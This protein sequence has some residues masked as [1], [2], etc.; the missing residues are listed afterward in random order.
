[1]TASPSLADDL[2]QARRAALSPPPVLA[3][4]AWAA[5]Y[6]RLPAGANAMPGRFVAFGYQR[7]WLDVM[8]DA[9]V[10]QCTIMKSARVGATRCL[11]HVIGYYIHQ[12]PAPIL[13]VL[14]RVEDCEDFSRSEVLPMLQDTPALAAIVGDIK[15][16]DANQRIL[17]RTFRNGASISFVGAT[18]PA[19]FRRIS[20]RIILLD[21]RRFPVGGRRGR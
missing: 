14:P 1:M 10:R 12:D 11:D 17:K 16:R 2:R 4:S 6:G 7:G 5:A 19:G 3:L 18:S 9:S 15:S 13:M 8:T 20:A 21:E